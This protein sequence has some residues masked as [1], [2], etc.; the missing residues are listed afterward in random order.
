MTIKISLDTN[1]LDLNDPIIQK[2]EEYAD[3]DLVE[4]YVDDLVE[5]EL[6]T[7]KSDKKQQILEWT[8]RFCK[9][10]EGAYVIPDGADM[11][12]EIEKQR[13]FSFDEEMEMNRKIMEIHSPETKRLSAVSQ[14][15]GL[16]KWTDFE[17]LTSHK[18][19]KRDFFL[20]RN[21]N[22]FVKRDKDKKFS[23]LGIKIRQ[24]NKDFIDELSKMV[25]S[26]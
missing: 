25:S 7:W 10:G 14:K 9:Q 12:K 4:L 5:I 20:T 2:L 11:T 26:L 18:M 15:A 8:W 21:T 23:E 19:Q 3:E 22:D 13:G 1:V 17:L 6:K 16:S 24:P